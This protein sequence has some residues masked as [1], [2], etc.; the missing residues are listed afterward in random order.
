MP[1]VIFISA[2]LCIE[3]I[4]YKP[5]Y[6]YTLF[7]SPFFINL[8]IEYIQEINMTKYYFIND[9][10]IVAKSTDEGDFL[11]D[12]KQKI[13]VFDKNRKLLDRLIGFDSSEPDG[14]PYAFG[15]TDMLDRVDEISEEEALGIIKG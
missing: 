3:M 5:K 12:V 7:F 15:N 1:L 14:S 9:L 4:I 10:G 6:I 13:W 2:K 8:V 11:F